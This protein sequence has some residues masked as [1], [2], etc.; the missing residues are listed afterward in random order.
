MGF[1]TVVPSEGK[2]YTNKP[3]TI[4]NL[5]ENIYQK[6]AAIPRDTS[7]CVFTNLQYHIQLCMD[8]RSGHFQHLTWQ[9]AVLRGL[10]YVCTTFYHHQCIN[11]GFSAESPASSEGITLYNYM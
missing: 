7:Q 5:K 1:F 10:R 8:A 11:S 9:D 4:N 2:V 3:H 6:I